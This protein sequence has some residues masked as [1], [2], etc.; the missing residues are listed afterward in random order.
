MDS[1]AEFLAVDNPSATKLTNHTLAVVAE[2]EREMIA[3]RTKAALW[4]AKARGV[5]LGRNGAERLA[6][7]YKEAAAAPCA[8]APAFQEMQVVQ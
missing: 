7:Q 1:E 4:T 8:L 2:H 5:R 3:A 6:P